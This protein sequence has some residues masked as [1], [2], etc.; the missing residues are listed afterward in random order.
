MEK[1]WQEL[2]L[3]YCEQGIGRHILC[4]LLGILSK[5]IL[6]RRTML[7]LRHNRE[8]MASGKA[9][10]F[11]I[12]V[13]NEYGWNSGLELS[14]NS[15]YKSSEN[16][17]IIFYVINSEKRM[18]NLLLVVLNCSCATLCCCCMLDAC[19]WDRWRA[20]RF[21]WYYSIT[22]IECNDVPYLFYYSI[23]VFFFGS[24]QEYWLLKHSVVLYECCLWA[25]P[26]TI[27]NKLYSLKTSCITYGECWWKCLESDGSYLI[28]FFKVS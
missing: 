1:Y 12:S 25:G 17:V 20:F 22:G 23:I 5:V 28:H 18:L 26:R 21:P 16:W 24:P 9:G 19:F 27:F 6:L 8:E 7:L 13:L 3:C 10:E 15:Y 4:L 11:I 14:F 2:V